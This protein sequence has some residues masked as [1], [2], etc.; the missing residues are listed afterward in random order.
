MSYQGLVKKHSGLLLLV[1]M[2]Y[3]LLQNSSSDLTRTSVVSHSPSMNRMT[4]PPPPPPPNPMEISTSSL[5]PPPSPPQGTN[6]PRN[7]GGEIW[8]KFDPFLCI[9]VAAP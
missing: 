4:M 2:I 8:I 5:P 9:G 1:F 3:C 7:R 6:A